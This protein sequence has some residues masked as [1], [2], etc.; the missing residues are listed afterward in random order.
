MNP[1]APASLQSLNTFGVPCRARSVRELRSADELA[2]AEFDPERDLLLGGGSNVLLVDDLEGVAWLNRLQGRRILSMDERSARIAVGAGENWHE[3]VCWTL[4]QGLH[5]LENLSLIPGS[6]G[7]API[8]NIGAY[9]VELSERLETLTAWDWQLRK[10]VTLDA[11]ACAFAYRDSRFKSAE[12]GRY[13][14]L[15][16]QLRLD[17]QFSPRLDYAGLRDTLASQGVTQPTSR[18][19]SNAVMAL[20]RAKLPDPETIGNAGS[21]FK[22]PEVEVA[23]AD[24][25]RTAHPGLPAHDAEVGRCKLSAGW[26]IERCGWKGFRE[27][28]AGVSEQH[29]L[30]LVNHGQASG[31]QILALAA[32][33]ARSVQGRF[34]LLLEPEPRLLPG[35]TSDHWARALAAQD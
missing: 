33:I 20:R 2:G 29:A 10:T 1:A 8:Q 27:G 21:F 22:N 35:A 26:L 13:W 18:A 9:G 5:G 30:V 32:R 34:G 3:L 17:R 31:Q 7:A 28:D 4:Q 25:L 24:A 14:I 16:I 23:Q 19:V 12:P 6:V 15:G 11:A